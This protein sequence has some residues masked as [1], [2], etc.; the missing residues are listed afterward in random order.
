MP[1]D[2]TQIPGVG[3][4]KA[5]TLASKGLDSF[6][7]IAVTPPQMIVDAYGE[8]LSIEGAR[9]IASGAMELVDVGE[10]YTTLDLKERQK[11]IQKLTTSS[12]ALD[13]LFGGGGI[14]TTSITEFYGEY[15]SGKTQLCLQLAVNATMPVEKGGLDGH[16][17]VI[18]TE[19]TFRPRRIE[20]MAKAH[21]L[22]IEETETKIHVAKAFNSAHQMLLVRQKA[23]EL[24]KQF[25]VRLV[26]VDSLVSHF[27]S[28]FI[29]RGNLGER[30]GLLNE[31]MHDL[32]RFADVNNAAV[33]VTNQVI[34]NPG[35]LFGDPTKP[36]G[37]NIVGHTS[38][39]RLYLR[40]SKEGMRNVRMIDSP[41]HPEN[42]VYIHIGEEGIRDPP[43]QKTRSRE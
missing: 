17:L 37:G 21:G 9:A 12:H 11:R 20:D 35:Q 24:A 27:R 18:D 8:G 6:M 10:F 23:T 30:Q 19:N 28:E 32:L 2:L 29:G 34:T 33:A 36:V 25:P 15:G 26:I 5:K 3:P 13:E 43:A 4:A 14:E 16:V 38:T 42:E 22:D 1:D 40:K 39:F 7:V 41:E 31:H